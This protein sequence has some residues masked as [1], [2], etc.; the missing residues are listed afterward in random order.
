MKIIGMIGGMSWE[1]TVVYYRLINQE[2]KRR[3]GGHHNAR[4]VMTTVDFADIERLQHAGDWDALGKLMAE[5]ARQLERAGADCVVLCTNTMH[6]VAGCIESAVEIPLLHI[7]DA[8]AGAVASAGQK[9]VGLL[10]TKFTMEQTFLRERLERRGIDVLIPDAPAREVIHRVI[11]EELVH[12]VIRPESRSEF[13]EI[14]E[15]LAARGAEAVILGCT[16]IGLLIQENHSPVPLHDT[17]VVHA[18]A[19]VEWACGEA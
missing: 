18:L 10:G 17:T 9:R 8:A 12:G 7:A 19:A 4:S 3:L 13:Q 1:S 5:A 6:K 16:E 11:Y 2:T 14:L 15:E